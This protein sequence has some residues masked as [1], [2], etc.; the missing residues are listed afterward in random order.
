MV[1][2]AKIERTAEIARAEAERA[3][4]VET[5]RMDKIASVEREAQMVRDAE[6]AR[7]ER[8]AQIV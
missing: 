4:I 7:V 5:Y 1:Q 2:F 6:L 8:E 3:Q